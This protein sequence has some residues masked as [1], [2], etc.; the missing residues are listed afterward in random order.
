MFVEEIMSVSE[1]RACFCDLMPA[2]GNKLEMQRKH[3]KLRFVH[4]LAL[5]CKQ[6]L[7]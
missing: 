2:L 3:G 5:L 7:C 4:A 6:T 1:C